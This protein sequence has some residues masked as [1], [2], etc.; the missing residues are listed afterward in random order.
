MRVNHLIKIDPEFSYLLDWYSWSASKEFKYPQ[1]YFS[2][3]DNYHQI[4][5]H[6]LLLKTPSGM[7]VDHV[8]GDTLDC[9]LS[10]LRPAT[11]SQ[12]QWNRKI[13]VRNKWGYKGAS[14]DKHNKKFRSNCNGVFQG[15]FNTPEEA[16]LM[17]CFAA[18]YFFGEYANPG[19]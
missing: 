1:S 6:T 12:N 17:Y 14:W 3:G 13:C 11:F 5:L 10:N 16:H 9:R 2:V 18:N 15:N 7:C 19:Y 8:N 4:N